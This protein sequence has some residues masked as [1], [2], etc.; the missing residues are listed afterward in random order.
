MPQAFRRS[1]ASD[2]RTSPIGI[3]SGRSRSDERTASKIEAYGI[4]S[5]LNLYNNVTYFLDDPVRAILCPDKITTDEWLDCHAA[6]HDVGLR[7][8][9]TI[10]FGSV[11]HPESWARHMLRTSRDTNLGG[12]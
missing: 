3:R 12:Q 2:P 4:Y 5:T 11:E 8:N 7:S 1:S 6:A 9:I 10:M